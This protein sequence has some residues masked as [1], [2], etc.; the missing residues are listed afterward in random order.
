M[1]CGSNRQNMKVLG[2]SSIN[3][4]L[5]HTIDSQRQ[6]LFQ[7]K[8]VC[9][10]E[11]WEQRD[12]KEVFHTTTL[13]CDAKDLV[14]PHFRFLYISFETILRAKKEFSR[15]FVQTQRKIITKPTWKYI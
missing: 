9:E 6:P 11:S 8:H 13:A 12:K 3:G 14:G 15:F 1:Q 2:K 5:R 10:R 4:K 7:V